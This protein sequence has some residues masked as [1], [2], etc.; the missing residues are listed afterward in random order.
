MKSL[1]YSSFTIVCRQSATVE[2]LLSDAKLNP[3]GEAWPNTFL[4]RHPETIGKRRKPLVNIKASRDIVARYSRAPGSSKRYIFELVCNLRYQ[5][6]STTT[7]LRCKIIPPLPSTALAVIQK[8]SEVEM[9]GMG[10]TA[11]PHPPLTLFLPSSVVLQNR[12][13]IGEQ[14]IWLRTQA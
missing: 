12:V 2:I 11:L 9:R 3:P 6:M 13:L 14:I 5:I 4:K 7:S 1:P 8:Q 10:W